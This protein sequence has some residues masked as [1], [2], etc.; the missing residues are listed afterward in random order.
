V[1]ASLWLR[2]PAGG[3][4]STAPGFW[5]APPALEPVRVRRLVRRRGELGWLR[6][7]ERL[8]HVAARY[9]EPIDVDEAGE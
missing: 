8:R 1:T 2:E 4:G 5:V 3:P 7:A 6:P 9:G